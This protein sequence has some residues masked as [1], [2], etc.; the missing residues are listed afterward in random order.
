M[1]AYYDRLLRLIMTAYYWQCNGCINVL[2]FELFLY[3]LT[4]VLICTHVELLFHYEQELL[5]TFTTANYDSL[6]WQ[7]IIDSLSQYLIHWSTIKT[8]IMHPSSIEKKKV[9]ILSSPKGFGIRVL[10]N[11]CLNKCSDRS[12]GSVTS[13]PY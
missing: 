7:V 9:F 4:I 5:G 2:V 12:V 11:H 8:A 6:L 13:L 1:A 10:T 3:N